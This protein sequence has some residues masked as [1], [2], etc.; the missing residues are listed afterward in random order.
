MADLSMFPGLQQYRQQAKSLSDENREAEQARILGT[1]AA[2]AVDLA[3]PN[4]LKARLAANN[5]AVLR[6]GTA[7][8]Y[9]KLQAQKLRDAAGVEKKTTITQKPGGPVE[10]TTHLKD[11]KGQEATI[12]KVNETPYQDLYQNYLEQGLNYDPNLPNLQPLAQLVDTWTGSRFSQGYQD[13]NL[14]RQQQLAQRIKMAGTLAANE[15]APIIQAYKRGMEERELKAK[16]LTAQAALIRAAAAK[17]KAGSK[18]KDIVKSLG[19]GKERPIENTALRSTLLKE[20]NINKVMTGLS[21]NEKLN[22]ILAS[23]KYPYLQPL[24]SYWDKYWQRLLRGKTATDIS[25]IKEA[26]VS[27]AIN[28]AKAKG[29]DKETLEDEKYRLSSD[30]DAYMDVIAL[31]LGD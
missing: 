20:D 8:A 23:E 12:K 4:N 22:Q 29:V 27:E 6:Q 5:Q 11:D 3:D 14:Q 26:M 21:K 1:I 28:N 7:N 10:T 19:I 30:I 15:K 9:Q 16:E 25:T 2:N 31:E 18:S 13:P 17:K 24:P